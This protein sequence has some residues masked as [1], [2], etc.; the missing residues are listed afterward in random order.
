VEDDKPS[1]KMFKSYPIGFFHIDIAE[2]RTEEGKLYLSPS[3]ALRSSPSPGW[4]RR[5]TPP[6][7]S[8]SSM[9]WSKPFPYRI[10]V[11]LTDNGIQ[12]VDLPKNRKGPT[13]T[14]RGHPVDAPAGSMA[15]SIGSPSPTTPG[16]RM[17][18]NSP[19]CAAVL[20]CSGLQVTA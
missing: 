17:R 3:P 9:S 15:S 11:V 2:V 7:P 16:P 10:S 6:P 14:L 5:P 8:P 18:L 20:F 1:K 12:F 13:A 4:S 19:F